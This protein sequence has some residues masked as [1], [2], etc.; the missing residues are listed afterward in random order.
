MKKGKMTLFKGFSITFFKMK[1]FF[2][3]VDPVRISK[4]GSESRSSNSANQDPIR[5]RIRNPERNTYFQ[6]EF[7]KAFYLFFQL[8]IRISARFQ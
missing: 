4:F 1:P 5:I 2:A 6:Q 3:H 7:S 8:Q